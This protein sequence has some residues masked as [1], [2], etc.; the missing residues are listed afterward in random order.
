MDVRVF[1]R[2]RVKF[3]LMKNSGYFEIYFL[4]INAIG[5]LNKEHIPSI[6][7]NPKHIKIINKY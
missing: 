2:L 1:N 7:I 3:H 5:S 6:R 4:F